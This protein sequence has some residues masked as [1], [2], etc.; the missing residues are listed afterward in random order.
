V[1]YG[2]CAGANNTGR[3]TRPN[4]RFFVTGMPLPDF[5]LGHSHLEIRVFQ[6]TRKALTGWAQALI[7]ACVPLDAGRFRRLESD[8]NQRCF[9]DQK[10]T[11]K[12]ISGDVVEHSV[13]M[14]QSVNSS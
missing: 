9:A 1:Q 6:I 10:L 3:K 2:I 8:A 12:S 5:R 4:K 13:K 14:E 7:K 11:V